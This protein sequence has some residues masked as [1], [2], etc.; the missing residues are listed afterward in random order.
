MRS[1]RL[2]SWI[3]PVP[4]DLSSTTSSRSV[5]WPVTAWCLFQKSMAWRFSSGASHL[6]RRRSSRWIFL[7]SP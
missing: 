1:V 5:P 4:L 2:I 6:P 3:R 7:S